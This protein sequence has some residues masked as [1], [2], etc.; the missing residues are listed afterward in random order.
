MYL[1]PYLRYIFRGGV[2]LALGGY[3]LVQDL[4]CLVSLNS[5]TIYN[6]FVKSTSNWKAA[7]TMQDTIE[8]T[9][10]IVGA[11]PAGASLSCFLASQGEGSPAPYALSLSLS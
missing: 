7:A 9:F 3:Y 11:G 8:T 4:V 2:V 6:L 10:L 1:P 5:C